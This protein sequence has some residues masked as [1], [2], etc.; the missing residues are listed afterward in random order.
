MKTTLLNDAKLATAVLDF[1]SVKATLVEKEKA[2]ADIFLPIVDAHLARDDIQG[3]TAFL[4]QMP[5]CGSRMTG[6]CR[7]ELAKQRVE[8][9]QTNDDC[10]T[11]PHCQGELS[12]S[13]SVNRT[14]VSKRVDD[15][16][17]NATGHYLTD[18]TFE[19]DS[20][21]GFSSGESYDLLDDSD[22]CNHCGK[23]V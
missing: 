7:I 9:K 8:R 12:D 6:S 22:S 19:N 2:L 21:D 5:A 14:Y 1:N 11:C 18:G 17:I 10:T 3:A 15:E 13:D 20:F 16:T 4:S 23:I